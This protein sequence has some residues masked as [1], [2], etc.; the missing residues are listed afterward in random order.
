MGQGGLM[1][2]VD[3]NSGDRD[4]EAIERAQRAHEPSMEEILGRRI[5]RWES[6]RDV[7]PH[8]KDYDPS[9]AALPNLVVIDGGK[10][11]WPP[12][13]ARCRAFASGG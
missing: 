10:G 3:S 6:Q 2:A 5:A 4:L 12:A 11:S 7:S 9:V 8:D 13:S 1:S